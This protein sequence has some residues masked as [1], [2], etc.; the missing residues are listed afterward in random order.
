MSP[1]RETDQNLNFTHMFFQTLT[2]DYLERDQIRNCSKAPTYTQAYTR[3]GNNIETIP[4]CSKEPSH[5]QVYIRKAKTKDLNTEK[6]IH[7]SSEESDPSKIAPNETLSEVF[8]N[9]EMDQSNTDLLKKGSTPYPLSSYLTFSKV[10]D[11]YKVFL[12]TLQNEYIP[13]TSDE[14]ITIPHWKLAMEEDLRALEVNQISDI[15]NLPPMKKRIGCWWVF[16]VKYLSD[17]NIERYKARLVAQGYNQTYGIDCRETFAPV[18]KMNIIRIL[19]AL[20]IQLNWAL[21]EYDVKNAFL[22][23]ELEE[24]IYMKIPPFFQKKTN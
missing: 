12:T 21:Q 16:T 24:E 14:V 5:T 6:K 9:I 23:G 11:D 18:A 8:G 1:T 3:K 17:G 4:N 7:R 20:A 13:K 19:V 22:H 2:S 15:V 10:T